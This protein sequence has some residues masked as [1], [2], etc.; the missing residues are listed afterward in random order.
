M[1]IDQD[2]DGTTS[3][4]VL[5]MKALGPLILSHHCPWTVSGQ[6]PLPKSWKIR[7]LVQICLHHPN[8]PIVHGRWSQILSSIVSRPRPHRTEYAAADIWDW[9]FIIS[10]I[11]MLSC[12]LTSSSFRCHCTSFK[13]VPTERRSHTL[14]TPLPPHICVLLSHTTTVYRRR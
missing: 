5:R 9:P 4:R 14:P 11:S 1:L 2:A 8:A 10:K 7:P 6:L 3:M 13:E 12:C